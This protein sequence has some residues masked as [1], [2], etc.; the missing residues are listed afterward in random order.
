MQRSLGLLVAVAVACSSAPA[1]G[2]TV[3]LLEGKVAKFKDKDGTTNDKAII[4]FVKE[5]ALT[6]ALADPTCP[7]VSSVRLK[8]NTDDIVTMLDC[9]KWSITGSGYTYD[10]PSASFGGVQKIKFMSR[11]LGGKLLIKIKGDQYGIN[12]IGGPITFL[13][14]TLSVGSTDYCGRFAPPAS[15]F[16]KNVAEKVIL[17]GPSLACIPPTPTPTIT[18]TATATGT[19]TS[20]STGT[21]TR[22]LTPTVTP[23]LTVPP[24]STATNTGTVTPTVTPTPTLVPA[25]AFRIDSIALRDP[26]VFVLAITCADVT[27]PPGLF[28][29]SVN[30]QIPPLITTDDD[31][32]GYLD[33]SLLA[34][35]RPLTQPP[36]PGATLDITTANCEPPFGMEVCH[37]DGNP[38]GTA[39][40]NNV[41]AGT[42]LSP[43]AGTVG[44]DNTIPYAPPI[45][46]PVGPGF[47]T[48]PVDIEF[49]FGIFNIPLQNVQAGAT[50]VGMPAT[51]VIDGL[52]FGFL[53]ESDADMILLPMTIPVVGGQPLSKFLPGGTGACPTHTAKD[54]GPLGQPGWYF[55]LNFTAHEVVWTGP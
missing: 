3:N 42:V 10:D 20:T 9:T 12:A 23:T 29:F 33:L 19:V 17:K 39:N 35:F 13:E 30:G 49:P 11:L 45:V 24:G 7:N 4:K 26:H 47:N 46:P 21:N 36:S 53:S 5:G 32:D 31:M 41:L 37:P 8:T 27:D 16:K 51:S 22:T 6:L 25:D 18:L 1:I 55:Y 50:Y 52:L 28:G 48:T 15:T 43:L 2:V 34:L 14:A 54:I 38:A 40:Y 44:M